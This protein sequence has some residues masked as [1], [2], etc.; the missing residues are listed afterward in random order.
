[1]GGAKMS[2][3]V[4]NVVV[5][6]LLIMALFYGGFN[7]VQTNY[8]S[9]GI[10][11]QANYTSSYVA[12]QVAEDDLATEVTGIKESA[13]GITEAEGNIVL[14]AW[15]GLTGLAATIRLFVNLI[16]VAVNVWD[17]VVPALAFLPDFAKILMETAIIITIVLI[18]IG[19]FKGETK[20]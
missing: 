6:M 19:S 14:V 9:G 10:E 1:M 18:V 15:N 7:F 20:T 13:E 12:L 17:A 2:M 5:S 4:T 11:D 8:V 16:G 3:S